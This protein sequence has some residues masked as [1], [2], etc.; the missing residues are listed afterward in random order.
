MTLESWLYIIVLI[1]VFG[2]FA[3]WI[4]SPLQRWLSWRSFAHTYKRGP[5]HQYVGDLADRLE[6]LGDCFLDR[7][8]AGKFD[9]GFVGKSTWEWQLGM[10]LKELVDL[11]RSHIPPDNYTSGEMFRR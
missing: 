10:D 2:G 7:S 1:L 8:I 5:P 6:R 4:S 3:N 11:V 9:L